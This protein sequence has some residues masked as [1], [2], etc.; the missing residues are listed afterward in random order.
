VS[1]GVLLA[2]YRGSEVLFDTPRRP[3]EDLWR[4]PWRSP[5]DA[6]NHAPYPVGRAPVAFAPIGGG[7]VLVI[8]THLR[9]AA[10]RSGVVYRHY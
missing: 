4:A 2:T 1:L 3:G 10:A 8:G 6:L 5:A 9:R 7:P